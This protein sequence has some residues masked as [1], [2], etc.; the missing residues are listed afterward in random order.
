MGINE[1]YHKRKVFEFYPT[2]LAYESQHFICAYNMSIMRRNIFDEYC[3]FLFGVLT[4]IEK[5]Y[6]KIYD[7][8][9]RYLG[10]LA[11]NLTSIFYMH[12]KD[13]YKQVIA[14]LIPIVRQ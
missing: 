6:L 9:D 8:R 7:R 5:H 4:E 14:K 3:Q 11:E 2:M 1:I 12:T 10:Y 13:K